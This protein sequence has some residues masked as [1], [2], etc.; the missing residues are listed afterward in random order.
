M[1]ATAVRAA[2]V[3]RTENWVSRLNLHLPL[4]RETVRRLGGLLA[5]CFLISEV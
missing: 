2:N 4:S 5:T 3:S 1:C